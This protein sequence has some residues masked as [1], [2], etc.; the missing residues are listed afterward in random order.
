VKA[1]KDKPYSIDKN[2]WG[3]SIECGPLEDPWTEPPEDAFEW[4]VSPEKAPNEPEYVEIT[5]E[6]GVPTQLNGKTY[7]K[8]S[9][10]I[11]DL[12][13][14]CRKAR[15]GTHRHGGKPPCRYKEQG[16]L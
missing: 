11:L 7:E 12:N 10:L 4:T 16:G 5:F 1:T 13:R 9:E 6:K 15:C 8:L 14:N 2:L 3:I